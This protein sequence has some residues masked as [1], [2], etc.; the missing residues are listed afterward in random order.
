MAELNR[1]QF[2]LY[3]VCA[4]ATLWGL[5]LAFGVGDGEKDAEAGG[6]DPEP[7]A[8]DRAPGGV[9]YDGASGVTGISQPRQE[10]AE[11]RAQVTLLASP[12]VEKPL[13]PQRGAAKDP[14]FAA[15]REMRGQDEGLKEVLDNLGGEPVWVEGLDGPAPEKP[16]KKKR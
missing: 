7:A 11:P 1:S 4:G 16:K 8:F 9:V 3:V 6:G 5:A 12:P 10:G 14:L 13:R 15:Q 2:L